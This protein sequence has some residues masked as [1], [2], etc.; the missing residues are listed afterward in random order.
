MPTN[1]LH[2]NYMNLVRYIKLSLLT[3]PV[4]W[5]YVSMAAQ[6][7]ETSNV[8][9]K[10]NYFSVLCDLTYA[11]DSNGQMR[12]LT[13]LIGSPFRK[14]T[15]ISLGP[16]SSSISLGGRNFLLVRVFTPGRLDTMTDVRHVI[17]PTNPMITYSG[18]PT[19]TDDNGEY[20]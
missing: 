7:Q 2:T 4:A 13:P 6:L 14:S 8:Q 12:P 20:P 19:R 18:A 1:L 11:T 15:P 10:K 16:E 9:S 3:H 5:L 17:A